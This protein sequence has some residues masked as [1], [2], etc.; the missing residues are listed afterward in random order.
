MINSRCLLREIGVLLL[1]RVSIRMTRRL[2]TLRP[3]TQKS[4]LVLVALCALSAVT[5]PARSTETW[6]TERFDREIAPILAARC[7]DC[8]KGTKSKGKLDLSDHAAALRGGESGAGLVP[9]NLEQSLIWSRIDAG[10][11]PPDD[12]LP[13]SER[14]L[15]RDWIAGRAI[16]GTNPIDPFRTTSTRRAGYDWWSLQPLSRPAVAKQA[17]SLNPIDSF[18]RARLRKARLEPSSP[19]NARTIIR[20]LSFDL[21]GLPPAPGDVQQFEAAHRDSP[22]QA[23][24]DLVNRLLDSRHFGER[25]GRHWLDV[26]RFG[27]S[28]GFERDRL[29][30][31]SWY[32]RDWVIDAINHDVP[33]DQFV[34]LQIA[35]DVLHPGDV[36]AITATGFLVAG[37]WDEVGQSQRSEAMKAVVRQDELEDYVGT[38][39]QTFL[40]LTV[41]C[42]RCHDHKF[43]PIR[44]TEYY[45]L[46]AALDG[47]RHGSRQV[48]SAADLQRTR[49]LD[50]QIRQLQDDVARIEAL[51]RNRLLA[52]SGTARDALPPR[53]K[54][55]ARWDFEK[56][57][58]DRIGDAH[59]V[60]NPQVKVAEG[61]LLLDPGQGYA[62][63][64]LVKVDLHEKTLETWVRLDGLDQGGGAVISIQ[65]ANG[66]VFDAIVYAEVEPQRW[67]AG[68]D[69]FSRTKSL[70]ALGETIA[71]Q[72]FVHLAITYRRDGEITVYRNGQRYG[73]SYTSSGPVRFQSGQWRVLFGLRIGEPGP[74]RQLRGK[75]EAAQIY[76]RALSQEEVQTSHACESTGIDAQAILAALTEEEQARRDMLEHKLLS[77]VKERQRHRPHDVYAVTPGKASTAHVLLRG[78]PA[79]RGDV[80]SPAGVA[81][82]GTFGD[83]FRLAHDAD[84]A[85]RRK[86]LAQWITNPQN[87]LFARVIINRLWHYHFGMGLVATPNDFGFNGG[88]PSHPQLL[89]WL[90][91]ELI[92][93]G[94]SLKHVHRLMVTSATYL[95][96]SRFRADCAAVDAGNRLLW[97]RSPAR[98][99]A[100]A[101]R[102]SILSVAGQLNTKYGG[103]PYRDF[104]TFVHNSQFYQM[105]DPD[106]PEFYRR[107]VYRTWIRSGRNHLLDVFD[108]PDPST[109]TPQ[110]AV[111]TTPIQSLALMNSSFVLR[112][113]NRFA[114]RVSKDISADAAAQ[115]NRVY[116]LA[117]GRTPSDEETAV[118]SEFIGAYGL[119]AFCRVVFNSNEFIH[120]D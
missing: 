54:P 73:K 31:T 51:A 59:A 77:L 7:L 71:D 61:R 74:K 87:P 53:V 76:D 88:R 16:W 58:N 40:G 89:D 25:W 2:A 33:Y 97:R 115:T 28:Q 4:A 36:A 78:N 110:R 111:T 120:V 101:L 102:D 104:D 113:A 35:G 39:G 27:E 12:P 48:V 84:D 96:A 64:P 37:P 23:I 11:M 90:A 34:R 15:I 117:Y 95:Q 93:S 91:S 106:G 81:A 50:Q 38:I 114:A 85:D 67:M 118:A 60:E 72:E 20:R 19:D 57:L 105:T 109:T 92:D 112:M 44:Q 13:E 52:E 75:I 6:T 14:R 70:G 32:Y 100:E 21:I 26:V 42:A 45:Q 116:E 103:P 119:P 79:N 68:S 41:H 94:W 65:S 63:T 107:T 30:T 10:E 3:W 29:R 47:V 66:R 22:Q 49:E 82:V 17:D 56:D 99:E 46:A 69:N 55:I 1:E 80:V 43:D 86:Q 62:K 9:G 5:S 108:C 98:L 8:H 83:G 24:G 18:V